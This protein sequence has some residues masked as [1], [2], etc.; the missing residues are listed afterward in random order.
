MRSPPT[1]SSC[2]AP[3]A[4]PRPPTRSCPFL[5]RVTAGRGIPDARLEAVGE[6]Y[7][8]RG[9]RS[10]INDLNRDLLARLR[11]ELDRRGIDTPRGLGQP[12]LRAVLRRRRPR[13]ARPRG[14]AGRHR[15]SRAPTRAT[16]PAGST[17]R[18][19]PPPS[20]RSARPPTASS[21]TRCGRT[22]CTPASGAPGC[23][24]LVDGGAARCPT[25]RPRASST[26]RTRSPRRWTTRPGPV[27]ARATSTSTSTC[28]WPAA[29]P[30]S[31]T[32]ELGLRA[33]GR[34][35]VLLAV[36]A[37][38][39]AVARAR[40]QRP[41]RGARRRGRRHRSSCAP[42]GFVSDHM[43]VV[44][45]LD[46][47]AA[48]TAE[49]VGVPFVRVATPGTDERLRRGPG[50]PPPRARGRGP[51]RGGRARDLAAGRRAARRCA[52]RA[53]AP[54]CAAAKPALCGQRLMAH[55]I[56]ACPTASTPAA[57][58][59]VACRVARAAGRLVVDERPDRPRRRRRSRPTPTR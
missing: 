26:S 58:E 50:R 31:S 25:R 14:H 27:T 52:R 59:E 47:E 5:R 43:E 56:R 24:A 16:R 49:R 39:P 12:Q 7:F 3:S 35:R 23:G 41:H 48:E 8:A 38:E 20:T 2:S 22:P 17:A 55:G 40:R 1:T 15:C 36:R 29:S 6:H 11:A 4:G 33:R 46:T 19:S 18:T 13:G 51:R 45:D 37:A 10:P 34:A 42:I 54:T 44:H 53:A 57:L 21:S 32:A 30:T 9:G 28:A